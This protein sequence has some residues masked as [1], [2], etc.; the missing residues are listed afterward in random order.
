MQLKGRNEK[1]L[2]EGGP[3]QVEAGKGSGGCA[4]FRLSAEH[5]QLDNCGLCRP[6]VRR[7]VGIEIQNQVLCCK[8]CA[9][10]KGSV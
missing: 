1:K 6:T 7:G 9:K 10:K 4:T 3:R 8:V 2:K 5:R